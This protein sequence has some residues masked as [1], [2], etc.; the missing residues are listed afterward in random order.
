MTGGGGGGGGSAPPPIPSSPTRW[1]YNRDGES[2]QLQEY[3]HYER[4]GDS[5]FRLVTDSVAAPAGMYT[6]PEQ[7]AQ[8]NPKKWL[9]DSQG[10][11][12]KQVFQGGEGPDD[13]YDAAQFNL[14]PESTPYR[15]WYDVYGQSQAYAP[16]STPLGE[17]FYESPDLAPKSATYKAPVP[18]NAQV[19]PEGNTGTQDL[20]AT[21]QQAKKR[22]S[23]K[24]LSILGDDQPLGG[25]DSDT[26]SVLGD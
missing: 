21:K 4:S 7:A 20:A 5:Q 8:K 15:H 23:Q 24:S 26:K 10:K 6:S 19:Q 12:I 11:A 17:G 2:T 13:E 16:T 18:Y 3:A 1:L 22:R 14:G 9:Y 25:G